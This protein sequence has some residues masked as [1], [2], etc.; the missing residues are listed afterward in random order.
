MG[1]T[2]EKVPSNLHGG[3]FSYIRLGILSLSLLESME[4][5]VI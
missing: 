3:L 4:K 5:E 2:T 1:F